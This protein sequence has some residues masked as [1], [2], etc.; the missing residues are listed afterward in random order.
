MISNLVTIATNYF[1]SLKLVSIF[2]D[3]LVVINQDFTIFSKIR[4][5]SIKSI[6]LLVPLFSSL[7]ILSFIMN[8]KLLSCRSKLRNKSF[9]TYFLFVFLVFLFCFLTILV[10]FFFIMYE[11]SIQISYVHSFLYFHS[12]ENSATFL[13]FHLNNFHSC[14]RSIITALNAKNK[15]EFLDETV[16]ES[17]KEDVFDQA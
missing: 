4:Y 1:L 8:A 10:P 17:M 15:V 14:S 9:I 12:F 11:D 5:N 2:N 13:V 16:D 3:F 6:T 7:H